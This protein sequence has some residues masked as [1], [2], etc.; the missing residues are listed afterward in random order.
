MQEAKLRALHCL[1]SLM[2]HTDAFAVFKSIDTNANGRVSR[3]KLELGLK[4]LG[5][6]LCLNETELDALISL[7]DVDNDGA[8]AYADFTKLGTSELP[9]PL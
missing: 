2:S 6:D 8:I 7:L 3:A 5:Q 1:K 4:Q 9:S